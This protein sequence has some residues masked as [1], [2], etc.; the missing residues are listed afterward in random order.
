MKSTMQ[1]CLNLP[2]EVGNQHVL[3]LKM[4]CVRWL[5]ARIKPQTPATMFK[6]NTFTSLKYAASVDEIMNI[7]FKF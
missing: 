4:Y 3:M 6:K 5:K 1:K 2:I 7:D